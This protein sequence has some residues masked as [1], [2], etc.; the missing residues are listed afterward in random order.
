M[1]KIVV[2]TI[3]E[4]RIGFLR[5]LRRKLGADLKQAADTLEQIH[6]TRPYDLIGGLQEEDAQRIAEAIRATGTRV[7]VE[8]SSW[9]VSGS[10]QASPLSKAHQAFRD[11]G[12]FRRFKR[13]HDEGLRRMRRPSFWIPLLMALLIIASIVLMPNLWVYQTPKMTGMFVAGL[14]ILSSAFTWVSFGI[15]RTESWTCAACGHDLRGA[16]DPLEKCPECGGDQR[17]SPGSAAFPDH[18][19]RDANAPALIVIILVGSLTLLMGYLLFG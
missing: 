4:K 12:L 14:L 1:W 5:V 2:E 11:E 19:R 15:P 9:L 13:V 7:K 10:S 17:L 6:A 16:E 8:A 3:P 18:V